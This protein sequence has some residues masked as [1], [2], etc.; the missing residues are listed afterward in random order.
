MSIKE[1]RL[2]VIYGGPSKESQISTK[3]AKSVIQCLDK[4]N[5]RYQ[6]LEWSPNIESDLIKLKPDLCFILMHG[7]G[8]E[9]GSIQLLLEKME[10]QYIGSKPQSCLLSYD[11]FLSKKKFIELGIPV[12]DY[13]YIEFDSNQ[14]HALELSLP[15][16]AKPIHEGSSIGIKIIETDLQWQDFLNN[17]QDYKEWILEPF[18]KGF[19]EFTVGILVDEPLPVLEIISNHSYFDYHSK[20]ESHLTRYDVNPNLSEKLLT[21]LTNFSMKAYKGF[22]CR[23][24]ARIDFIVDPMGNPYILEINSIPGFTEKSLLPMAAKNIGI[25]FA[26]LCEKLIQAGFERIKEKTHEI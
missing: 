2:L 11:K 22:E 18:L 17:D 6:V 4:E 5:Y 14:K 16:I 21:Q 1:C 13:Q 24:L 23:D 12:L 8:G 20:Y 7:A 3:S 10:I 15:L 9:D 25:D 19:R 26:K